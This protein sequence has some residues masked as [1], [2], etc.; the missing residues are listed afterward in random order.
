MITKLRLHAVGAT[1][2]G[3][4]VPMLAAHIADEVVRIGSSD[5]V[6]LAGGGRL[7]NSR[8]GRRAL[9]GRRLQRHS[10]RRSGDGQRQRV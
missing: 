2:V 7:A 6:V 8:N 1:P 10:G 4:L 3:R 5:E 9:K